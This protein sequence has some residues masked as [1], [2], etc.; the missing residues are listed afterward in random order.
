[1]PEPRVASGSN[2]R[3]S[4]ATSNDNRPFDAASRTTVLFADGAL[5]HM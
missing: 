5:T 4:S 1:M 3:P 2:P